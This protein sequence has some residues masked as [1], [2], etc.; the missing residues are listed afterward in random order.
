MS[1]EE[2]IQ[3]INA[4][5]DRQQLMLK[6]WKQNQGLIAQAVNRYRGLYERDDL[7]QEAYLGLDNAVRTYDPEAGAS[8]STYLVTILRRWIYRA[9]A[10]KGQAVRL[11][12][13]LYRQIARVN[14]FRQRILAQTGKEPDISCITAHTGL[15]EAQIT[16]ID[17]AS[18]AK[19]IASLD[20][21]VGGEEDEI[22]LGDAIADSRD[23]IAD[24]ELEMYREQM[25]RDV[26]ETVDML[27]DK[28]AGAIRSRYESGQKLN[29]SA[30]ILGIAANTVTQYVQE[31]LRRL[32]SV[33]KYRDRLLP[34]YD[35]LRS[36]AMSGGG[37]AAFNH[38]WT[39]STEREALKLYEKENEAIMEDIRKR[40]PNLSPEAEAALRQSLNMQTQEALS[41]HEAKRKQTRSK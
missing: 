23:N 11:P 7:M 26:W 41:R 36:R 24:A 20:S 33:S 35:G 16:A 21:P 22:S 28:Y 5:G 14:A 12:E 31:G 3:A 10:E 15:T 6:L 25:R 8:F 18:A 2:I 19:S 39:S 38:S 1:N 30:N 34:Y 9:N 29:D 27:P 13:G 40:F 32:R 17:K 37:A 4:G